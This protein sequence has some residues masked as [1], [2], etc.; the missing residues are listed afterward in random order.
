[1]TWVK[2]LLVALL[3]GVIISLGAGLKDL[4]SKDTEKQ[5]RLVKSLTW[6]ISLSF[7]IFFLVIVLSYFGYLRPHSL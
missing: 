6:R 7:L 2:Y 4:S 5:K 3:V 1:M